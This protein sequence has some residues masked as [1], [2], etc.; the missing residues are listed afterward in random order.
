MKCPHCGM[1]IRDNITECGYCGG[2]IEKGPEKSPQGTKKPNSSSGSAVHKGD[3][4]DKISKK[5]EEEPQ[6]DEEE[7]GGI[8]VY[9]Q[10]GEQVLIGSL[11]IAVK[12]F[13]FHAYLTNQRI[14][15][16]DTQEKKVRVTAKDI[17]RDAIVGSIMEFS[18]NSDPVLVISFK[19]TDDEIKTMK[20]IFV[21]NGMDRSSEIDEWI[22]LLHE[23]DKPKKAP[24]QPVEEVPKEKEKGI[25]TPPEQEKPAPKPELPPKRKPVKEPEKQ[26]PVKRHFPI[27]KAQVPEPKPEEPSKA[28]RRGSVR[29]VPEP[30]KKTVV[31]QE[32]D[33]EIPPVKKAEPLP[34]RKHEVQSAMKVAMKSAMQPLKASSSQPV[35]RPVIEPVSPPIR[36][37]EPEVEKPV[38]SRSHIREKVPE[39]PVT[40]VPAQEEGAEL[41]PFC[42]NCGKKMPPAANFCPACGTKMS[43]PKT[44]STSGE[45]HPTHEKKTTHHEAPVKEKKV[46]P[47]EKETDDEEKEDETPVA[48]KL[49]PKKASKGNDMTILHKFLRR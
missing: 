39:T 42:H 18:E 36:E 47:R 1:N 15:L 43:Q 2:K 27:I 6:S 21:Q 4:G 22:D 33:R 9:L 11:N 37:T 31:E 35:K 30:V 44:Q 24:V 8:S 29:E 5:Q 23:K 3:K 17:S 12:K 38:S 34:V 49:P 45:A 48:T 13:F 14:F 25:P 28:P 40:E 26:P 10:Q 20:L 46:P 7:E 32:T 19:S 41:P 16:I